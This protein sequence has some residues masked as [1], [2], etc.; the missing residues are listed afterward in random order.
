MNMRG[1]VYC[2]YAIFLTEMGEYA[3]LFSPQFFDRISNV[4]S[5]LFR[6]DLALQ[7]YSEA[8]RQFQ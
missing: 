3:S 8:M 2:Q 1:R 4:F 7:F 6:Y 5:P